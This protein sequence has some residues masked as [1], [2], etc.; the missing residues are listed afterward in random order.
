[1]GGRRARTLV[2]LSAGSARTQPGPDAQSGGAGKPCSWPTV[3]AT[4]ATAASDNPGGEVVGRGRNPTKPTHVGLG[5]NVCGCQSYTSKA[6][7]HVTA[8]S[9]G[10]SCS[11]AP[12]RL[13]RH[14]VHRSHSTENSHLVDAWTHEVLGSARGREAERLRPIERCAKVETY[15]RSPTIEAVHRSRSYAPG[16]GV[17]SSAVA[18]SGEHPRSLASSTM[19]RIQFRV[20]V[21]AEFAHRHVLEH[22]APKFADRLTHP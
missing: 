18:V 9:E 13:H 19:W 3:P 7:S 20:V 10:A 4:P 17:L 21:F 11:P 22:A 16:N 6:I 2:D 14:A 1:M 12:R 5:A 15:R 8:P